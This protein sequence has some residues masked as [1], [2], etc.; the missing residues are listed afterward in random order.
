MGA[1]GRGK[2]NYML[3][4]VLFGSLGFQY[5]TRDISPL[6]CYVMLRETHFPPAEPSILREPAQR[7][8]EEE[9]LNVIAQS[10][11][12]EQAFCYVE[13]SRVQDSRPEL[14]T[15]FDIY[16]TSVLGQKTPQFIQSFSDR[17]RALV[18][19]MLYHDHERFE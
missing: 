12:L 2:L 5:S 9:T 11:A 8:K 19:A 15:I 13:Q 17:D 7:T 1:R 18:V 6:D 14:K 16:Q 10:K 3:E 4:T